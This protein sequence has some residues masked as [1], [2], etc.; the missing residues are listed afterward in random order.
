[1]RANKF[2]VRPPSLL[3][4]KSSIN[5]EWNYIVTR[6]Y[7]TT[8]EICLP[9]TR[10]F[11]FSGKRGKLWTRCMCVTLF[12]FFLVCIYKFTHKSNKQYI[13]WYIYNYGRNGAKSCITRQKEKKRNNPTAI[14]TK[15]LNILFCNARSYRLYRWLQILFIKC[16]NE[17]THP[18]ITIFFMHACFR[19]KR[20]D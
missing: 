8:L 12:T 4:R 14:C 16:E 7:A 2:P 1:M 9:K 5:W 6:I 17:I 18:K 20:N 15:A 11:P 19:I 13:F 10:H 3:Q